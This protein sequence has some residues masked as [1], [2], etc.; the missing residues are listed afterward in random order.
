MG[1]VAGEVGTVSLDVAALVSAI[2]W[3]LVLVV[4]AVTYRGAI[5]RVIGTAGERGFK[6]SLPGGWSFELPGATEA[7]VDWVS[8]RMETD[9]RRPVSF[10]TITDS[11]RM[12]FSAQLEI[13]TP[14]Q[15]AVV[16]IGSGEEW[17]T[18]RLYIMS[19]L[20]ARLR[21]VDVLVFLEERGGQPGRFAG[22]APIGDVRWI[23]ARASPRFEQ[24]FVQAANELEE[25]SHR[26]IAK[27]G[28]LATP[29]DGPFAAGGLSPEQEAPVDLLSAYLRRIQRPAAPPN[30]ENLWQP[31]LPAGGAPAPTMVE[32][33][34]WLDAAT[35]RDLL[36]DRLQTSFIREN[37]LLG[38][39]DAEKIRL[40]VSH[41]GAYVALT[42]DDWRLARLIDRATL[43]EQL[44]SAVSR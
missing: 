16:D 34:R 22:W 6:L 39:P 2:V 3:P 37:E 4:L 30:E 9:L 29:V 1:T 25:Q 40:L 17:L 44:S 27:G 12:E 33:G 10:T 38:K 43:M 41:Q 21:S 8:G 15:Y 24:A 18:S 42:H 32:Q 11:T 5:G 23:L 26:I 19:I 14:A 31:L 28:V 20:L 36:G 35:M 7:R 13:R